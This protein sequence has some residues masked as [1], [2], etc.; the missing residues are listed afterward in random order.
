MK[1]ILPLILLILISCHTDKAKSI[2]ETNFPTLNIIPIEPL[3]WKTKNTCKIIYQIDSKIDTLTARIRMRGGFSKKYYKH[4]FRLELDSTL[5]LNTLPADDDWI[6]NANYIDKTFMRHKL[7]YDLFRQMSNDNIAVKSSYLNLSVN[8]NYEGLY[9]LM[10]KINAKLL[11][12]DKKD[13]MAMIFK[14]PSI[15]RTKPYKNYDS[16]NIYNQKYPKFKSKDKTEYLNQFKLFLINSS[17]TEFIDSIEYWIDVKSI[18][19][20]HLILL[21]TGNGDGIQKNFYLYKQNSS[22]PFKIAI[23]DYDFSFG[24]EGDNELFTST[25]VL[26]LKN[27]IIIRRL[28]DCKP[29]NYLSLLKK[30]WI[31]LREKSIFTVSNIN[32]H[33]ANNTLSIKNELEKNSKRWPLDNDWYYDHNSFEQEIEIIRNYTNSKLT[34]IDSYFESY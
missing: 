4:S 14:E 33:I 26:N 10:E 17:E 12:L 27:S 13:S 22:T 30:R 28:T 3:S 19:D 25:E 34:Q 24:R 2:I 7:S 9:I 16:I 20:W 32:K 11:N 23:W 15:F 29:I 31:E 1:Y 8:N 18:I 6:L 5:S 21:L